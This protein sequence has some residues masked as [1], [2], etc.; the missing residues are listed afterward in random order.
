MKKLICVL[1]CLFILTG[2][3]SAD[4]KEIVRNTLEEYF[5]ALKLNDF[6][7]ANSFVISGDENFSA[8]IKKSSVNDIIFKNI[9]IYR[10]NF[11]YKVFIFF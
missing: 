7:K 2:C 5:D 1:L 8:E 4:K 11:S 3:V 6:E 9:S 10:Y